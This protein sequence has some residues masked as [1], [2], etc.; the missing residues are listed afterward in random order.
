MYELTTTDKILQKTPFSFDVSVWEFFWPLMYGATLVVARPEGHKDPQYLLEII[1]ER[2]ITTLHFVPSMLQ[3]FVETEGVA[4]CTSLKRIICSGE[5]LPHDLM[6]RCLSTLPAELHNLYGPTEAAVDVS[7]WRCLGDYQRQIVPIGRPITNTQLYVLDAAFQ[8]TPV[9]VVGEL[10]IGGL[11]LARGYFNQPMLTAEKFIPNPFSCGHSEEGERL[12]KTGDLARWL[13]DG[14]IEFLGRI[15]HQVKIRGFR[16][17]LEEIQ[18]VLGQHPAVADVVVVAQTDA[19]EQKRLV[20]YVVENSD[21][22]R[23]NGNSTALPA[24]RPAIWRAFLQERVPD[25]MV[26]SVFVA[27]EEFPLTPNGKLDRKALPMPDSADL[28]SS[29]EFVPP[30]T[31]TEESLA[32]VWAQV[33][34][35]EQV[36]RFDN[37]F[38]LGGHSLLAT[39][40][41]SRLQNL[42]DVEIAVRALFEQPSLC[43]LGEHL[44]I[45]LLLTKRQPETQPMQGNVDEPLEELE[46]WEI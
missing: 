23:R 2:D 43:D 29:H 37:F 7:Y 32:T 1:K 10:Y 19:N 30:Q 33:L 28:V 24:N 40:V 14:N 17:E 11:Q 27:L 6:M 44:D 38:E 35:L 20:A 3:I 34:G 22:T 26:P 4:D 16:I 13:P 12:Y 46:E 45:Q 8:P 5:A 39:Q 42:F 18:A 36:G 25:Y 21:E 9:G 15:D 41:V 31:E